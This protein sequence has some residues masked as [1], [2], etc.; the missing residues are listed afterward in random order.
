[1]DKTAEI[2]TDRAVR[3][4]LT[5]LRIDEAI[6]M[7]MPAFAGSFMGEVFLRG[8]RGSVSGNAITLSCLSSLQNYLCALRVFA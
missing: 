7:L 8:M 6:Q 2:E 4:T 3:R 5:N 1:M